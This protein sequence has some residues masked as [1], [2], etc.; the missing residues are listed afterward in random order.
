M[1]ARAVSRDIV[2]TETG[3]SIVWRSPYVPNGFCEPLHGRVHFVIVADLLEKMRLQQS[4]VL[5]ILVCL[6]NK[7]R[8]RLGVVP[9]CRRELS[10][11]ERCSRGS[12]QNL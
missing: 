2:T 1:R 8:R 12:A 7:H 3:P 10:Q 11:Q 9:N 6:F 4:S 5:V